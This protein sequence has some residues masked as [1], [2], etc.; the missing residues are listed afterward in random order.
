MT[1][2]ILVVEDDRAI[3]EGLTAA[4]TLE[5]Y[6]VESATDGRAGFESARRNDLALLILDIMLPG[7][8]GLE[9]TKRLRDDGRDVPIILLTARGEEDDRVLGL[10]L[11]A[12]DYVTKPFSVRELTARVR[13]ILR[14]S[15]ERGGKRSNTFRFGDVRVDFRRQ[16]VTRAGERVEMSAREF[17]ILRYFIEHAGEMLS[18]EQ[19]LNDIWGYDVF[20]T[21]RTVDNHIARLR[22]KVEEEPDSPRFIRTVRGAGYIF[23]PEAAEEA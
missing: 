6:E 20:P 8:S 11:G 14:R 19:L 16:E 18:R 17:R 12:D 10:E 5:G 3:V 4:L 15:R 2:R 9:I 13:S 1:T 23:D 22:K 21:T 7:M